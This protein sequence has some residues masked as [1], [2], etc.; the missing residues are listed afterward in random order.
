LNDLIDVN[1]TWTVPNPSL[2][3]GGVYTIASFDYPAGDWSDGLEHYAGLHFQFGVD[4]YYGWLRFTVATDGLSFTIMDYAY[5]ISKG[6]FIL[7]GASVDGVEEYDASGFSLQQ[8]GTEIL[9]QNQISFQNS[10]EIFDLSGKLISEETMN[11]DMLR[12]DLSPYENGIYIIRC[13]N[14]KGAQE[15]KVSILK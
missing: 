15:F 2:P 11:A 12:L 10:I 13:K 5:H 9:I 3:A 14:E 4:M 1:E 6:S 8:S 7:A